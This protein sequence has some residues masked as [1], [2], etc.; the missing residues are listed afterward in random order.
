MLEANTFRSTMLIGSVL[1]VALFVT[2]FFTIPI[3]S[4]DA[5]MKDSYERVTHEALGDAEHVTMYQALMFSIQGK[6]RGSV[7]HY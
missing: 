2:S 7:R 5:S 3:I 6:T 1:I 4:M